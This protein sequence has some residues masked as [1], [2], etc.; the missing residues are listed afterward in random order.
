MFRFR[1]YG[2]QVASDRH[3]EG[4]AESRSKASADVRIRFTVRRARKYID[5]IQT[6]F[7]SLCDDKGEYLRVLRRPDGGFVF[8]FADGARFDVS[9]DGARVAASWAENITFLD[10]TSYLLGPVLGFVVRLRGTVCLHA[11]AVLVDGAAVAFLAPGGAGKSSL[12]AYFETR[13]HTVLTD[14]VLALCPVRGGFRALAGPARLRLW[15]DAAH[16]LYGT[17]VDLPKVLPSDPDWDKRYRIVA[18]ATGSAPLAAMY[19]GAPGD[20]PMPHV[21]ALTG[22]DALVRLISHRYPVHLPV[23]VR[24]ER[25]FD[26]LGALATSVPMRCIHAHSG[27]QGLKALHDVVRKDL[28]ALGGRAARDSRE[29]ARITR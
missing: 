5:A 28:H 16:Y 9:P 29:H 8:R 11:S 14:D 24:R 21:R 6:P 19:T 10:V 2:L 25:E 15:P 3:I 7:A 1:L 4:I 26:V 22:R 23:P 17:A 27:L 12:C 20:R 13:G 18:P